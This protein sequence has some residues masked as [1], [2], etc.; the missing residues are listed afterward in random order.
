MRKAL[1]QMAR[2]KRFEGAQGI[3]YQRR[4]LPRVPARHQTFAVIFRSAPVR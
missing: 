2:G 1:L 4:L 3:M